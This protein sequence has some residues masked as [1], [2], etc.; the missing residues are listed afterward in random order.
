MLDAQRAKL[1]FTSAPQLAE[2]AAGLLYLDCPLL[3]LNGLSRRQASVA[4]D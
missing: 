2:L 1:L 3:T 4:G